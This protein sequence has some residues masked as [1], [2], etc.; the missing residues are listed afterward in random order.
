MPFSQISTCADSMRSHA[1]PKWDFVLGKTHEKDCVGAPLA[2]LGSIGRRAV[3]KKLKSSTIL[4][5]S[6]N[7]LTPLEL[8][9]KIPVADAA[10]HNSIHVQTFIKHYRH[11][12]HRIGERRLFVTVRDAITLPPPDSS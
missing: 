11:L 2:I 7:G 6:I 5:A 3:K 9:R 1:F 12:L 8:A 4:P 10:A